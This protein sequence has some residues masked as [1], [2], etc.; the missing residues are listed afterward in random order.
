M[1]AVLNA[2]VFDLDGCLW[3]P[4][5]Y[6]LWG[7]GAPFREGKSGELFDCSGS[8]VVL[9]GAVPEIMYALKTDSKWKDTLC[10]VASCTDEP[11]WADECMQKFNLGIFG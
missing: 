2:C 9:L 8:K 10:A 11:G 7:G 4:D 5:M 1:W 3:A 6:M